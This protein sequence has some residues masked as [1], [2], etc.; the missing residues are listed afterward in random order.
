MAHNAN[1]NPA[2]IDWS[3]YSLYTRDLLCKIFFYSNT[4]M[5]II[6]QRQHS[7]LNTR[8][9]VI[10]FKNDSYCTENLNVEENIQNTRC[11]LRSVFFISPDESSLAFFYLLNSLVYEICTLLYSSNFFLLLFVP[12]GC[13]YICDSLSC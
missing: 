13:Q 10:I 3:N 4:Y 12:S 1:R 9:I 6:E 7:S 11:S 8:L 2:Q 5:C